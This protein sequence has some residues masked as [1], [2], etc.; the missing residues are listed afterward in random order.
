M[1]TDK[2]N[3]PPWAGEFIIRHLFNGQN[4]D[5]Q[6]LLEGGAFGRDPERARAAGEALT[7]WIAQNPRF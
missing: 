1:N 5:V 2:P 3:G 6:G 4:P 7:T